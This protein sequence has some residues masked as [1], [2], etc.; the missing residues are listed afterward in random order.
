MWLDTHGSAIAA[1]FHVGLV[2]TFEE[3]GKPADV[4]TSQIGCSSSSA[5]PS[6]KSVAGPDGHLD[7][8]E[9]FRVKDAVSPDRSANGKPQLGVV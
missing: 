5:Q 4:S 1:A 2:A 3:I 6:A 9:R 8:G 7:F